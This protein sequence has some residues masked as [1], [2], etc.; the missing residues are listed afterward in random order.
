MHILLD[1]HLKTAGLFSFKRYRWF[2]GVPTS[3]SGVIV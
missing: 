2:A 1:P 3:F